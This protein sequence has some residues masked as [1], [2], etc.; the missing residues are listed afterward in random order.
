MAVKK[1]SMS[2]MTRESNCDGKRSTLFGSINPDDLEAK[3]DHNL[4][5]TERFKTRYIP[6]DDIDDNTENRFLITSTEFL[7]KSI[8]NLGQLQP[9]IVIPYTKD[10]ERRYEIKSGSRRFLS[11]KNICKR[12]AGKTAEKF[13]KA[14]CIVLPEGTTDEE[15]ERVITETN[16]TTRQISVQEIF[17]N[18]DIIFEKDETGKYAFIPSGTSKYEEGSRILKEM[19]FKFSPASVKDYLTIYTAHNQSIRHDLENGLLSKK[20]ALTI[21]RMPSSLQDETMEKFKKMGDE[22]IKKYIKEYNDEKKSSAKKSLRGVDAVSKIEKLRKQTQALS[23]QT[24]IQFAGKEQA[25][26]MKEEIKAI[27][28]Y[29][30][31]VEDNIDK[32]IE[33]G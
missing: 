4:H 13:S 32:N 26:K 2:G 24:Y 15:I 11:L 9:I 6:L 21:A 14:F 27:K 29:I 33:R 30:S 20:Q 8:L 12:E 7:E 17:M 25:E 28:K 31:D 3:T 18:F 23:K 1:K 5:D 16:T 22:E 19:G 10:G